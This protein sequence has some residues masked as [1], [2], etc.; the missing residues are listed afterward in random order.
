MLTLDFEQSI[1]T[2]SKYKRIV[3]I[4]EVGRGC[5]AGP[6][7]VGAYVTTAK[8]SHLDNIK[9]SKL[10]S[11]TQ[12]ETMYNELQAHEH[13][14]TYSDVAVI[15]RGGIGKAVEGLMQTIVQKYRDGSTLILIDG[16]HSANFGVDT[17]KV[18]K[19]DMTYYSIAAASILAKVHRD[20][21]MIEQHSEYPVYGFDSHKGYATK[22]HRDSIEQH[23]ICVLHRKSFKPIQKYL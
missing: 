2:T 12:R 23:G 15:D 17:L 20:T 19:G 7:A 5:W 16:Q 10:L 4:D 8:T 14:V 6:V 21:H 11:P 3:G 1:L 18:L 13:V 9:D 22:Q